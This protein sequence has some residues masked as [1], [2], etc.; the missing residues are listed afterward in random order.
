MCVCVCVCVRVC[1]CVCVT[2]RAHMICSDN[3]IKSEFEQI[4]K[5]YLGNGYPEEVIFDTIN[6][7]VDKFKNNIGP[8]GPSKCPVYVRLPGIGSPRL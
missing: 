5:L 1:V 6:E 2:F 3:K 8:L 7:T 4:K